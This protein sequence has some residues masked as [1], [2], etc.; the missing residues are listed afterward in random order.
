MFLYG[1]SKF[2]VSQLWQKGVIKE[3]K[4]SKGE[5]EGLKQDIQ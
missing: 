5:G 4:K 2:L 3:E 1:M